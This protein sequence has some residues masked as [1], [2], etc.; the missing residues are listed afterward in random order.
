[1][2]YGNSCSS[3]S[4]CSGADINQNNQ[5]DWDDWQILLSNFGSGNCSQAIFP[6]IPAQLLA[7]AAA[8]KLAASESSSSESG[9]GG[10]SSSSPSGGTI[11]SS[12]PTETSKLS[13]KTI[14]SNVIKKDNENAN[15]KKMPL[16]ESKLSNLAKSSSKIIEKVVKIIKT[17]VSSIF[18]NIKKQ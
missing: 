13:E 9:S 16:K 2:N 10:S 7:E 1:M 15:N 18:S 17:A 11:T 5:V 12:K 14:T 3:P 8:E 6:E 4:W